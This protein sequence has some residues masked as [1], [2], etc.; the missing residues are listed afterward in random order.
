[1]KI[2]VIFTG[3]TIGSAI[4][5]GYISTD[6]NKAFRLIEMYNALRRDPVD[7]DLA[8]PFT[9]LS[10]NMTGEYLSLLGGCLLENTARQYDGIIITHG[11]DTIQYTAASLS[12]YLPRLSIPVMLVCSQMILDHPRA[13][14]LANFDAAVSFIRARAG[15]GVFVPYRNSDGILY[16]HRGTRLLPHLPYSD[17]L[18]SIR[19]QYYGIMSKD[20]IFT[21]KEVFKKEASKKEASPAKQAQIRLSTGGLSLP[22]EWNSH[23]LRLFPYPGMEYPSPDACGFSPEDSANSFHA[24]LLDT[25]H[26]GT[27]CGVTPGM[28]RFFKTAAEKG[29]PVFLTGA[30]SGPDYDSVKLWENLH[31]NILPPASPVAMYMKL[32]MA[33]CS[34]ELLPHIPLAGILKTPVSGDIL[35]YPE[36]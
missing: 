10:E 13:N 8:E 6:K 3:G 36:E 9:L 31:V 23:I 4:K 30:N 35:P 14:G 16:I 24:V 21:K 28:E 22:V 27:I 19:N 12:Y 20:G 5:E 34:T 25:Y 29:I 33:L 1:M 7:F 11:S 32:W 17:D 18:Y 26:S 2:L 15:K